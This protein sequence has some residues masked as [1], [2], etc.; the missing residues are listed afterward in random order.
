[1]PVAKIFNFIENFLTFFEDL[2]VYKHIILMTFGINFVLSLQVY[3][4]IMSLRTS[5]T[6]L[7]SH[8]PTQSFAGWDVM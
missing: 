6:F 2:H 8:F 5:D 7:F 4:S 1:M 3:A